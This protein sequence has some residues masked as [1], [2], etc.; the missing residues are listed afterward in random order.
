MT[1]IKEKNGRLLS[2]LP[3]IVTAMLGVFTGEFV[4][5]KR[6]GKCRKVA[7]MTCASAALRVIGMNSITIYFA[8]QFVDFSK[9][10]NALFGGSIMHLVGGAVMCLSVGACST[11]FIRRRSF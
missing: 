7:A 11:S 8:Q 9:P 2:S 5:S 10:V 6:V 1:G 3:A 4:R